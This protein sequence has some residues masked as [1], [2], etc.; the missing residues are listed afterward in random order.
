PDKRVKGGTGLGLNGSR[1]AIARLGSEIGF[2]TEIGHGTTFFFEIPEMLPVR[3]TA[4]DA[5]RAHV[6]VCEDEGDIARILHVEDDPDIQRVA[7]VIARD[8]ATFEF[9]STLSEARE[10]LA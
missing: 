7:A 4:A 6:L 3:S 8:F 9:A 10:R 5:A 2:N 1:A